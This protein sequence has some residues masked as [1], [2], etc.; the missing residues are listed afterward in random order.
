MKPLLVVF[1]SLSALAADQ[2]PPE[3]AAVKAAC[4]AEN[5]KFDVKPSHGHPSAPQPEPGKALV[6]VVEQFD[7]P[8]SQ[9]HRQSRLGWRLGGRE[10]RDI[11]FVFPRRTG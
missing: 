3:V 6:Y 11:L 10:P 8:I 9:G 7:A 1:L 2:P 5:V 4:G